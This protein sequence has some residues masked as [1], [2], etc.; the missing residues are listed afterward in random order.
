MLGKGPTACERPGD[1]LSSSDSNAQPPFDTHHHQKAAPACILVESGC[2]LRR[3][4]SFPAKE[5]SCHTLG[6]APAS[7]GSGS[8]SLPS[9]KTNIQT[10]RRLSDSFS[11]SSPT[12]SISS[13][14]ANPTKHV[15][16]DKKDDA[17]TNSGVMTLKRRV[18]RILRGRRSKC[19]LSACSPQGLFL[20]GL[21]T[22]TRA[23]LS[24][25]HSAGLS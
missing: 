4:Q 11:F 21:Q 22:I 18:R 6:Y 19:L 3:A 8:R 24:L 15:F 5:L 23:S 2:E 9:S 14:T 17:A 10:R 25:F 13:S 1:F 16:C 7:S 20:Q 12:S